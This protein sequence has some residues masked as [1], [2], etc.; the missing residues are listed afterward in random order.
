MAV[1]KRNP[2]KTTKA[3]KRHACK[4]CSETFS[5]MRLR[6]SHV[7]TVHGT[8]PPPQ[9]NA[10]GKILSSNAS[11][12]RHEE[13]MHNKTCKYCKQQ[14][15]MLCT[16]ICEQWVTRTLCK[17]C[18]QTF[19]TEASLRRHEASFRNKT[20]RDCNEQID[21]LCGHDCD[22]KLPEAI[23]E[24][25]RADRPQCTACHQTFESKKGLRLHKTWSVDRACFWCS[26]TF[27]MLCLHVRCPKH[28]KKLRRKASTLERYPCPHCRKPFT[29][30][31]SRRHHI[32]RMTD[33][34]CPKCQKV[35]TYRCLHHC[36]Q[37][38]SV[39]LS[40]GPQ[41]RS[42]NEQLLQEGT[43]S[44]PRKKQFTWQWEDKET[45]SLRVKV[46]L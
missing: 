10:C 42:Q 34:R 35:C 41:Q 9:C 14:F 28:K 19:T 45:R 8:S 43:D 37:Q 16:H 1:S 40:R 7:A 29:T 23:A 13:V 17:S 24:L 36:K 15:D 26:K 11:L 6:I 33:S 18:G 31:A 44:A 3:T 46:C 38:G 20:C 22:A 30:A 4:H 39:R 32:K 25:P 27:P 21:M 2:R 12:Q 5:S